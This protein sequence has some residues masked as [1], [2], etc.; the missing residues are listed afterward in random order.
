V[1]IFGPLERPARSVARRARDRYRNRTG[2]GPRVVYAGILDGER[3]W[4][5]LD[6]EAGEPALVDCATGELI[7]PESDLPEGHADTEPGFRSVRWPLSDVL[8]VS[9]G[10]EV[11]VVAVRD[12]GGQV[13]TEIVR[14]QTLPEPVG[15]NRTLDSDED[16]WQFILIRERKGA[17]RVRRRARPPV[18]RVVE[19]RHVNR[20]AAITVESLGR[21]SADLLLLDRTQQFVLAQLPMQATDLGFRRVVVDDDVPTEPGPYFAAFGTPED[22]VPIVRR[23]NDLFIIDPSS[24]LLPVIIKP[25]SDGDAVRLRFGPEG[26][27]RFVRPLPEPLKETTA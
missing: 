14:V 20:N 21:D 17:L 16:G 22:H 24:A 27:L 26:M 8:P 2:R 12:S 25:G 15:P 5:A 9:D 4:L 18:A 10:A 13:T 19:A 23:D 1:N 6:R 3:L 7:R 11:E